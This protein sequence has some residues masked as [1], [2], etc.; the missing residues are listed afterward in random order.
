ME[1]IVYTE[2]ADNSLHIRQAARN[3]HLAWLKNTPRDITLLAAGP[4]LDDE[5]VM[6]GSL[7][8]VEVDTKQAVIDWLAHDPYKSV[9]LTKSTMIKTYKWVIGRPETA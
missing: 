1:F 4:W 2:D 6:R 9:G 5:D 3:D 8:I 7:L